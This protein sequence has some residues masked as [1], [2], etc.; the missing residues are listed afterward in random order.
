MIYMLCQGDISRKDEM[1]KY[2]YIE[3]LEWLYIQLRV[4]HV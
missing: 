2:S 3:A 4:K 1:A